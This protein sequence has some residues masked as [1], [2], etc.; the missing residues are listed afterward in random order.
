MFK[1]KDF[2]GESEKMTAAQEV[3][4]QLNELPS[5]IDVIRK[6]EAGIDVRKLSWSYDIVLI[7]DFDNMTD[8]EIYTVHPAHQEFIAFNKDFSINK[9]CIDYEM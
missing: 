1:L 2:P 9:V 8:L 4:K 7:M 6:Y 5:K 3:I